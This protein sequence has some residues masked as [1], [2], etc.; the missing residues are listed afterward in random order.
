MKTAAI[1]SKSQE[2]ESLCLLCLAVEQTKNKT[3]QNRVPLNKPA[4]T[5]K[6]NQRETDP[7]PYTVNGFFPG[8]G[9]GKLSEIGE[10]IGMERKGT[11]DGHCQSQSICL[12][13][14]PA[15]VRG[16]D[17]NMLAHYIRYICNP[18]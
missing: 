2:T 3:S 9:Q 8:L 18:N 12:S 14:Y 1:I 7:L 16:G 13:V 17:Q 6:I 4:A 15:K 5:L 10:L 11:R